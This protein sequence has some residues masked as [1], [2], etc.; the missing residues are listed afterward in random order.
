MT[1][2][3]RESVWTHQI[4]DVL[5]QIV[6]E[7]AICQ[8]KL[9]DPGVIEAVLQN[10]DSVCGHQNPLA[11]KK[12]REALMLGFMVREKAYDRLGPVEAQALIDTIRER[13]RKRM[14][15]H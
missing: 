11:F 9:T 7:A 3:P 4:D 5:S 2:T 12:L 8:V 1:D 6:R 10:N 14:E 13:L 15:H